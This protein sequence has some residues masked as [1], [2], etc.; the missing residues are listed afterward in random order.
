M[1]FDLKPVA[2]QRIGI[3][4]SSGIGLATAQAGARQGAKVMLG[5]RD[6]EALEKIGREL[7]RS[8]VAAEYA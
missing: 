6:G 5:A 3:G 1:G 2:E 7:R 4:A 8:G